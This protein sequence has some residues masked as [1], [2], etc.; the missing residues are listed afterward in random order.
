MRGQMRTTEI[1]ADTVCT[2]DRLN[3]P[4]WLTAATVP[5]AG[6]PAS[7]MAAIATGPSFDDI[8]RK[9]CCAP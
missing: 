1:I 3:M 9:L 7:L 2:T 4:A 6:L 5:H 8:Q